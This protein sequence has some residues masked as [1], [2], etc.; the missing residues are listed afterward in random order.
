MGVGE[1]RRWKEKQYLTLEISYWTSYNSFKSLGIEATSVSDIKP[2]SS[3]GLVCGTPTS[4]RDSVQSSITEVEDG[5][6]F[7]EDILCEQHSK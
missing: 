7:N 6:A 1:K 4:N 3:N 2:E 5:G